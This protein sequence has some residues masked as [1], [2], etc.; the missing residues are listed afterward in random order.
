[1]AEE[2][3]EF[4][5]RLETGVEVAVAS[6]T[7][8]KHLGV[9]D[10]F[11]RYFRARFDRPV[12]IAVVPQDEESTPV[13][14]PG[15]D[16]EVIA[17]ARRRSAEMA[18]RLGDAYDFYVS[19]E[20]GLDCLTVGDTTR[21]VVRNWTVIRSRLGDVWGASG[22]LQL[23]ERLVEGLGDHDGALAIPGTRRSGGLI[24]SL[25]GGLETR[26][27]AVELA[28]LNALSSQFYGLL[29]PGGDRL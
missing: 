11:L 23:P 7:P 6:A 25:T 5:R 27:R 20:G 9:R 8:D 10:G 3:R 21:Y 22:S 17:I 18:E 19:S 28:T 12:T 15:S 29:G 24:S 14:L 13:G 2:I 1:M 26:R 4:W 16:E